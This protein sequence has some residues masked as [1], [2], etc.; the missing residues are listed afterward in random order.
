M[1]IASRAPLTIFAVALGMTACAE[2]RLPASVAPAN[3]TTQGTPTN[4]D[5]MCLTLSS[6]ARKSQGI[7]GT[8]L[9]RGLKD[10][11]DQPVLWDA[12]ETIDVWVVGG[13]KC[14]YPSPGCERQ[15]GN[16][17][18]QAAEDWER[19][20]HITFRFIESDDEPPETDVILNFSAGRSGVYEAAVGK[21]RAR[22]KTAAFEPAVTLSDIE[23]E[24]PPQR[25]RILRHELG[26]I[27][28]LTHAH[29]NETFLRQVDRQSLCEWGAKRDLSCD[30]L[31]EQ[32]RPTPASRRQT[33][34]W[35]YDAHSVMHYFFPPEVVS[36]RKLR[37]NLELSAGDKILIAAMYPGKADPGKLD[38]YELK[39]STEVYRARRW[40]NSLN[41]VYEWKAW[42]EAAPG[43]QEVERVVYVLHPTYKHPVVEVTSK[44]DDFLMRQY[45]WG[46][47]ELTASIFLSSGDVFHKT[48]FIDFCSAY[49]R[50]ARKAKRVLEWVERQSARNKGVDA[51]ECVL[52]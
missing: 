52:R 1:A 50:P 8:S 49:H 43:K 9:T 22:A 12:G 34:Q 29:Q 23:T 14:P 32:I 4:I 45:G 48:E 38:G 28:G 25:L 30:E 36:G 44:S 41:V 39:T 6:R 5:G 33:E 19:Y 24:T 21:A 10:L 51:P 31:Y 15:L 17:L 42:V 2:N 18:R 35:G 13:E 3:H 40:R 11:D 37:D 16:E 47:F 46:N 27:L 7:G 26:H 20:A